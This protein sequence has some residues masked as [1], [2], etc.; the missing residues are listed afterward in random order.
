MLNMLKA[1]AVKAQA[2]AAG[3]TAPTPAV[4]LQGPDTA[5]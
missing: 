5:E 1:R 3:Q 2:A 4:Y